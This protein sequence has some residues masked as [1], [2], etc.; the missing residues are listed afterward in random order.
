[1]DVFL[2]GLVG[3]KGT[4]A[5]H[6]SE[7]Q[8]RENV[9]SKHQRRRMCVSGYVFV[10]VVQKHAIGADVRPYHRVR[11]ARVCPLYGVERTYRRH[12]WPMISADVELMI[13]WHAYGGE[14]WGFQWTISRRQGNNH[15][16]YSPQ[17]VTKST[18]EF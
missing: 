15:P 16:G 7:N 6:S 11:P 12:S 17:L 14:V 10:T 3:N 13:H 8:G 1:M 18:R 4:P 2:T 5:P 9:W